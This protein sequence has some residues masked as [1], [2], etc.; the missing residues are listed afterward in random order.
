MIDI[1]IPTYNSQKTIIETLA[2]IAIQ[3]I[4]DKIKIYIIDDCSDTDYEKEIS[5]FKNELDITY[6]R[7]EKNMGP[8]ASRQIGIDNSNSEYI[9]FIDSDDQFYNCYSL[10]LLFNHIN[11]NKLDIVM[12]YFYIESVDKTFLATESYIN[13]CLHGK[14]YRREHI[15][16][17]NIRFNN[18]RYSEDNSFNSLATNTSNKVELINKIVYV[19]KNNQNSLTKDKTK[20]LKME[21]SYLHNMLWLVNNLEKRNVE[22]YKIVDILTNSYA[23]I[24]RVMKINKN[25]NYNKLY[26]YCYGYEKKFKEYEK[27]I[28]EDFIYECLNFQVNCDKLLRKK[29]LDDFKKFRAKFKKN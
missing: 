5:L 12:G 25:K 14:I 16:A 28:S 6:I 15:I 17:N 1:I 18:S 24:Y 22:L 3:R 7:N 10:E 9:V 19:Y 13:G 4:K 8:G 27:Y 2:S 11:D 29:I 23:Y 21:C 20:K 26:V